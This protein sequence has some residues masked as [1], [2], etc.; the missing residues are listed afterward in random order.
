MNGL[1][2]LLTGAVTLVG[3][4]V[5]ALLLELWRISQI[6]WIDA[7]TFIVAVIPL[8]FISIPSVMASE[9][10][11]ENKSSFKE[12]FSEGL[13][14]IKN[15]RGFL[16]FAMLATALNFLL[17]PTGTLF[18]YFVKYDHSG[19]SAEF[20]FVSASF[21]GGTLA[22]GILMSSIKGF[23]RKMAAIMVSVFVIFLGYA[24]LA[25]TPTGQFWFMAI[26]GLIMSFCI[27]VANVSIQTITQTVTPKKMLGRVSSVIGALASAASPLGMVLAGVLAEFTGIANLFLGCAFL[28]MLVSAV[29]W[30]F[31]DIRYL[32]EMGRKSIDESLPQA[33]QE[34]MA[35]EG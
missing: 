15:A 21:Q 7:V 4:V 12:E 1:N 13:A 20:A 26:A 24:L 2:Y 11:S 16:T 35:D 22:G 19:G 27:P 18:P 3:P 33:D 9:D 25:L 34:E 14:F 5:A 17:T 23:K 8:F 30:V 32:E 29:S 28:G 10:K 31:T 6:L